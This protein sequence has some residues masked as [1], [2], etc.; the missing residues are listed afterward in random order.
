MYTACKAQIYI[1]VRHLTVYH[2]YVQLS[3]ILN[4]NPRPK[5]DLF[6]PLPKPYT[7]Y[8]YL[9]RGPHIAPFLSN[10]IS[11]PKLK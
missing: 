2:L 7:Q 4:S 5:N 8:S 11:R 1:R 10:L 6:L 3:I 9:P